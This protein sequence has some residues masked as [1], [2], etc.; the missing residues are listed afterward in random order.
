[1]TRQEIDDA[2]IRLSDA[3]A[4][5]AESEARLAGARQSLR[6][7]RAV[8][9]VWKGALSGLRDAARSVESAEPWEVPLV[10]PPVP[11]GGGWEVVESAAKPGESIEAGAVVLRLA[12]FR[13]LH[14]RMDFPPDTEFPA[15]LSATLGSVGGGDGVRVEARLLGPAPAYDAVSQ[16]RTAIYAFDPP[17]SSAPVRPGLFARAEVPAG[18]EVSGVKV[19]ESA[20]LQHERATVVYVEAAPGAFVRRA[21]V[22]DH[23]DEDWAWLRSGIDP[24][25]RV[26]TRGAAVLLSEEFKGRA[27]DDDD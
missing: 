6:D 22:L 23:R 27:G 11:G 12:S 14:L 10:A 5:M 3:G 16:S 24:S 8:A 1:V 9:A 19:P 25:D 20:V 4:R 15:T 21:V 13:T 7:A 18:P 26:V 2:E 17:R